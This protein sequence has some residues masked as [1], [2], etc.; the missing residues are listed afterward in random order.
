[1]WTMYRSLTLW[2][3]VPLD[4]YSSKTVSH[5]VVFHV[6]IKQATESDFVMFFL[7]KTIEISQTKS[8][9][10]IWLF[11]KQYLAERK[12]RRQYDLDHTGK[13]HFEQSASFIPLMYRKG[14]LVDNCCI[15]SR[16]FVLVYW[17]LVFR[18]PMSQPS[19]CRLLP[20]YGECSP[21]YD[22]P[23]TNDK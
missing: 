13:K 8:R 4:F 14:F 18:R 3:T 2:Q 9:G 20:S 19:E 15:P 10:I 6:L 23:T 17:F 11:F 22:N 21:M 1:M 16:N 5:V 7:S 12:R